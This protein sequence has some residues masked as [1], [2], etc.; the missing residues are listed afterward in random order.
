MHSLQKSQ[1]PFDSAPAREVVV[2]LDRELVVHFLKDGAL[3][4]ARHL[5]YATRWHFALTNT[6][7][8][9]SHL[10]LRG[11]GRNRRGEV[12]DPVTWESVLLS[13]YSLLTDTTISATTAERIAAAAGQLLAF[14]LYARGGDMVTVRSEDVRSP[15]SR[16]KGAAGFWTITFFPQEAGVHSKT[17][18]VDLAKAVAQPNRERAWIAGLCP[19]LLKLHPANGLLLGLT[20]RRWLELFHLS[21]ASAQVGAAVPHRLR[22]GG[23]SMDALA[24]TS[25]GALMERGP[26]GSPKAVLRYRRPGRYIKQ[27]ALLTPEQRRQCANLPAQIMEKISE[28]TASLRSAHGSIFHDRRRTHLSSSMSGVRRKTSLSPRSARNS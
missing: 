15:S 27:L 22:H 14:D 10:S 23:A 13:A 18:E 12:S 19:L 1:R 20:Q 24:G 17:G 4:D 6:L 21:R 5:Y 28:L 25:D 7:L 9:R 16:Q 11:Y 3:Q 2:A 26:W 8:R